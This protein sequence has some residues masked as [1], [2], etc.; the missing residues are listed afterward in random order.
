LIVL[1]ELGTE[2][3]TRESKGD[4]GEC[5][6]KREAGQIAEFESTI[7]KRGAR[8]KTQKLSRGNQKLRQVRENR[9]RGKRRKKRRG[10]RTEGIS[11][12]EPLKKMK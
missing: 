1:L 3:T 4:E 5:K 7:S 11:R 6:K 8:S 2:R 10:K 12:A 9:S